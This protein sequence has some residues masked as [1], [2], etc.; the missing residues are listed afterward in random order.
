MPMNRIGTAMVIVAAFLAATQACAQEVA[1]TVTGLVAD[2]QSQGRPAFDI[3]TQTRHPAHLEPQSLKTPDGVQ[4]VASFPSPD[5]H[6]TCSRSG[7]SGADCRQ[8]F[9]VV[10]DVGARCHGGG[11][12][13]ALFAVNCWPGTAA[14]LCKPGAYSYRFKLNAESLC[15]SS[16][17]IRPTK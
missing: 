4:V 16:P 6:R 14:S 1:A 8:V 7:P 13:E 15:S 11:D 2:A 5:N 17:T 12:Y 10:L 9:R 3:A